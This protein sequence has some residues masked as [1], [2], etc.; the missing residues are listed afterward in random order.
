MRS[1]RAG[2]STVQDDVAES[3]GNSDLGNSYLAVGGFLL[4]GAQRGSLLESPELS[5]CWNPDF[6][7]TPQMSNY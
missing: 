4:G 7:I 1:L 5:G 3:S 2:K 6:D